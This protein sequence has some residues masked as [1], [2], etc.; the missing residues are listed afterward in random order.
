MRH[1]LLFLAL[2]VVSACKE[3]IH[4]PEEKQPI[5][6][7]AFQDAFG[8]QPKMS[9]F[10]PIE[11]GASADGIYKFDHQGKSYVIRFI[12][13]RK[14]LPEREH[15][16]NYLKLS[17]DLNIGPKL[18]HGNAQNSVVILSF[19]K[20][21]TFKGS[22]EEW[23]NINVDLI[24]KI[25]AIPNPE[26]YPIYGDLFGFIDII[27]KVLPMENFPAYVAQGAKLA[28]DIKPE[29]KKCKSVLS[30]NDMNP[31][32]V[33][34]DGKKLWSIDWENASKGCY[35]HDLSTFFVFSLATPEE[36]SKLMARYLGRTATGEDMHQLN[37][38][39]KV[40]RAF[41][42][43]ALLITAYMRK[44][45]APSEKMLQSILP[46]DEAIKH[47]GNGG[48]TISNPKDMQ[49]LGLSLLKDLN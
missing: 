14:Q 20:P 37:Q 49:L 9:I 22:R 3:D 38:M 4:I 42:G 5:V 33:I 28:Q 31:H 12:P 25:H 21:E 26:P 7:Q 35:L 16:I 44:Q 27:S 13:Q 8:T 2:F 15:E 39:K 45:P 23:L 1:P 19:I 47:M 48:Y 18:I 41:Y 11:A 36:E 46:F 17:G 29:F 34:Y 10:K 30:H 40:Q 32:N 24:K 6:K 43:V